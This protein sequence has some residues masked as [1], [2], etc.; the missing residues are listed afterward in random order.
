[1]LTEAGKAVFALALF[2]MWTLTDHYPPKEEQRHG[3]NGGASLTLRADV[4]NPYVLICLESPDSCAFLLPRCMLLIAV[5]LEL[6]E[7]FEP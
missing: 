4:S 3:S 6:V 7:D 2:L 1:M 5:V